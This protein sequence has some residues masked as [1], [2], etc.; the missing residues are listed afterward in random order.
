MSNKIKSSAL[1]NAN[2]LDAYSIC[3]TCGETTTVSHYFCDLPTPESTL[4]LKP[5]LS[6]KLV[7]SF[8]QHL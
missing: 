5:C 7:I 1:E 3:I 8:S 6:M 4:T 2:V